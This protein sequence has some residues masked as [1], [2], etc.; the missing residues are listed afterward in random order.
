MGSRASGLSDA[1][2]DRDLTNIFSIQSEVA[3]II[4]KKLAATLSP[5]EK[6]SIEEKPTDNLDAYDFYLRAKELIADVY[7]SFLMGNVE[8]P[9]ENAIV[10]LEKATHLD[11]KFTL[12]YCASAEVHDLLYGRDDPTPERRALGDAAL[13]SAQS[14]QPD[15]PEVHLAYACHL[16]LGYRDY[17]RARVQLAIA[18]RGL[19]NN[20]EA[21][22][23]EINIDLRQGNFEKALQEYNEAVR[24]DPRNWDLFERFAVVLYLTRQFPTAEQVFDRAIELA[25]DRP[26]LKLLR[27]YGATYTKT[28]D[29]TPWRLAIAALPATMAED[30][31]V[32]SL[33]LSCALYEGDWQRAMGLVD[34]MK[35]G[36]DNQ[37]AYTIAPVPVGCYSILLA[38]LQGEQENSSFA[39][40]REQLN[41][42][43][44]KSPGNAYLLS[45]LAVVDSL[46]GHKEVA[47]SEAKRAIEMLSISKDAVDGPGIAA[48]LAIVYA[49]T[50]ELDLA[51]TTLIPL[52]KV[53]Y[54]IF[55]GQLKRDPLWDPI[56]KDSR[57]E[58][59]LAELAPRD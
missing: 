53:P 18:M 36:E 15:L 25:P 56:R 54:G 48:N 39:E 26:I 12:A 29:T 43:V 17:D 21:I 13:N 34:K 16:F 35:G 40:T 24:R 1:S 45:N 37:F 32:L 46:L 8:K 23:L 11:P 20:T 30:R 42:K 58:K 10:F 28:G 49:W 50:N 7:A 2:Y 19:P 4:A 3:Q 44:Q 51:F 47:I 5:E 9:L 59:L 41:Q 55:Y 33:H 31:T 57:Y 38:R 22:E 6:R 52:T 14:L 27:E